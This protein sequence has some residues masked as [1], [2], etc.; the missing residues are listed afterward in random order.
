[1]KIAAS[2]NQGFIAVPA[3][4]MSEC[5]NQFQLEKVG[6]TEQC[7]DEYYLITGERRVTHPAVLFI[8]EHARSLVFS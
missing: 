8:S 3:V 1:M 4:T 5:I 6:Q 2:D 7:S